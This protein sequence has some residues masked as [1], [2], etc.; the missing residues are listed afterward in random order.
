MQITIA[1][2]QMTPFGND[3]RA[4]LFKGDAF[5][6]RAHDMGT[7]IALFPEMWNIGYTPY[8]PKERDVCDVWRAPEQWQDGAISGYP[9]LRSEHEHQKASSI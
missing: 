5:C 3:Q 7:D 2:L 9:A 6:R 8:L 4:N 1:L